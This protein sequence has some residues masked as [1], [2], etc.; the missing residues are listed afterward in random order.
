MSD[1]GGYHEFLAALASKRPA[2]SWLGRSWSSVD[3]WRECGRAKT[4]DLLCYAPEPVPPEPEI[5]ESVNMDGYTRHLV[6][7]AVTADRTTQAFLLIPDAL[8][9]PAPAV[10]ALHDHGGFYYHGK[11]KITSTEDP[12]EPL[13]A[14]I[15]ESYGGRPYA[16]ALCRRGVV[17]L[18]PDAFYFGSQ[19]LDPD[20]VPPRFTEALRSHRPGSGDYVRAYHAFAWQHEELVARTILA[21]GATWPGILFQGDRA[22]LDVLLARPEVDA[23]RVGC[24]GLSIGGYRAAHLFAL[25]AR[26]HC[27]VVAG[28]MTT[29]RSLLRDHIGCHTWMVYIPGQVQW[30]DLP[31]VVTLNAPRPLMVMQCRRDALFTLE[32]MKDAESRIRDVYQSLGHADRF[33][34]AWYD[35]PHSLPVAAQED[36]FA[37]LDTWLAPQTLE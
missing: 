13:R 4:A 14:H 3:E 30:L 1:V 22:S 25:D 36:A 6:R 11:E 8:T 37:W 31:D 20:A 26:V 19:R 5:L 28:W 12:S 23:S 9:G 2:L 33:R 24:M 7:Y 15:Q 35:I 18:V 10:M 27:A 16:D 17:V 34:C 29:Y 21:A 32:G